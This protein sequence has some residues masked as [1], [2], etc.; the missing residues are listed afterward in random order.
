MRAITLAGAAAH[1]EKI[2]LQAAAQRHVRRGMFGV[3][4]AVFGFA[5]LT[6]AHGVA[7]LALRSVVGSMWGSVS[8]LAFDLLVAGVC[9]T[10]AVWSKPGEL[11]I[12]AQRLKELALQNLKEAVT[13]P[14]LF[15]TI[16]A[17][18][19]RKRRSRPSETSRRDLRRL[20][21]PR[22]LSG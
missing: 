1:A 19:N 3:A 22:R 7:W 5:A 16:A 10:L 11:E 4:G 2:R 8:L 17:L 20:T 12:E 21:W 18:V 9:L 13:L 6:L 14:A 15:P